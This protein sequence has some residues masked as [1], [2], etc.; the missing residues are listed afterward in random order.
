M[1]YVMSKFLDRII[2]MNM[3]LPMWQNFTAISSGTSE[4]SC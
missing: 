3:L 1:V 4:I 2:K